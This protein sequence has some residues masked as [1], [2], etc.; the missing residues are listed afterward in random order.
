MIIPIK[1]DNQSE[2]QVIRI[3]LILLS[4]HFAMNLIVSQIL[5]HKST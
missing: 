4:T 2:L 5:V 1:I 3:I